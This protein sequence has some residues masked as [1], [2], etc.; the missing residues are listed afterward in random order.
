[1]HLFRQ[2]RQVNY[3][4]FYGED[5]DFSELANSLYA[6]PL[7]FG[8][9]TIQG[10]IIKQLEKIKRPLLQKLDTLI[11]NLSFDSDN[12]LILLFIDSKSI[13]KDIKMEKIKKYGS[14][15][16]LKS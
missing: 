1:M 8:P 13:P 12:R 10:I 9:G 14:I 4:V 6:V 3:S 15:V 5:L 11:E 16:N 7:G 2:K